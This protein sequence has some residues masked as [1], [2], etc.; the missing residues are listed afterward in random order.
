M[1]RFAA[2]R[3]ALLPA[4]RDTDAAELNRVL[5]AAGPALESLILKQ[6]LGPLWHART[7]TAAF[8][9]SRLKATMLYLRQQAAQRQLDDVLT[10]ADIPYA[11]FKGAAI[12]ELIYDDPSTR[13][14]C[15]I[16][17]LVAPDQRAAAARAL[18]DAGYRL[19]VDPSLA[20]HEVL[21]SLDK[22]S[23]DLHWALLR[24]GRTPEAMAGEMLARRQRHGD[25]WILGDSD[26]LFVLLVHPA[27]SKHMSTSQMGLHR[28]ADIVLWLQRYDVDWPALHQQLDACG[29]K[30]AAWTMLNLVRMLSPEPFGDVLRAPL[31]ALG[32]D[33][34][35]AAYLRTWLNQDLS[36]R[37]T[38]LHIARLMGFSVLLHDRPA[39][40]WRAL[41]GWQR[42]RASRAQDAAVF[43]GLT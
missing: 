7:N 16:D 15:D 36:A 12:R 33:R 19:R 1:P 34:L 37:F 29:V 13:V 22:V 41:R 3:A 2:P 25:R 9:D 31:D 10:R 18:V 8:A 35:R 32:P 20:S 26:I 38:H 39:D 14:C 6:Q 30:T 23:I 17:V 43:G 42:S 28:I 21:L 24:P 11:V 5:A 40:A 27:F 4:F